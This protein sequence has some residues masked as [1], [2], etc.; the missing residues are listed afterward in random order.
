M[1]AEE[2]TLFHQTSGANALSEF[3]KRA[4]ELANK[5]GR[6]QRAY[7]INLRTAPR[8][9]ARE[10]SKRF[11]VEHIGSPTTEGSSSRKEEHLAMALPTHRRKVRI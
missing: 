7:E 5:I 8:R 11:L 9:S 4:S 1:T 3:A 2:V 10:E 6:T